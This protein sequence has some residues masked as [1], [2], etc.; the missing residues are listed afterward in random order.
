[1]S[2][3]LG[4]GDFLNSTSRASTASACSS[5]LRRRICR[6]ARCPSLAARG[7]MMSMRATSIAPLRS[8]DV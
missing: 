2:R 8:A 4:L 7:G 6:S 1:M 3:V 5:I